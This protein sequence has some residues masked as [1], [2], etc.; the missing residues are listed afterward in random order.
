MAERPNGFIKQEKPVMPIHFQLARER[1]RSPEFIERK[2]EEPAPE[3][4]RRSSQ[5]P[6]KHRRRS[7]P[8]CPTRI[9]F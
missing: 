9:I 8:S 6:R 4:S 2:R 7:P 3:R 1:S 5:R